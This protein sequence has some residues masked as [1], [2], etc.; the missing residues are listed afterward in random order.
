MMDLKIANRFYEYRKQNGLSQEELAEKLGI[1]R[2]SVSKWERGEA[3]PDT[4]NLIRLARIYGV[5][6]DE[7]VNGIAPEEPQRENEPTANEP[8]ESV[9]DG[10]PEK[11][12]EPNEPQTDDS[13]GAAE[14]AEKTS[15]QISWK[16]GIHVEDED[17]S[18]H[19]S[20]KDGIHVVDGKDTVSVGRAEAS[21]QWGERKKH[22]SA[23][24]HSDF[25]IVL[26]TTAA[27]FWLGLGYGLWHPVWLLFLLIPM[28]YGLS[29]AIRERRFTPF[30]F[31]VF[32]AAVF[33]CLGFF[34]GLWH[35]GWMVFLL[36]PVYYPVA[37]WLDREIGGE[38]FEI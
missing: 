21:M 4:E 36:I 9:Q 35:P 24:K 31:P 37:H 7:L 38:E 30:P 16:D 23:K 32:A 33:L 28:V 10:E 29:D 1:S 27:F 20:W 22:K 3:S 13:D 11:A 12:E 34:G 17:A 25:P 2:Q 15:V 6:L 5:T 19:I 18:V 8:N 26:V 14:A